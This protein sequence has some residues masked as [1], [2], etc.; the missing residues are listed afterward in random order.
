[1]IRL[2]HFRMYQMVRFATH[3]KNKSENIAK[4]STTLKEKAS[5]PSACFKD[6]ER[7]NFAKCVG[8]RH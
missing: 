2:T 6:T 3:D 4:G 5:L 7:H 8:Q 1:M